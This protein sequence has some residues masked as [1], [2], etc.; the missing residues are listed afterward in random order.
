MFGGPP[1]LIQLWQLRGA[2]SWR[3]GSRRPGVRDDRVW[4]MRATRGRGVCGSDSRWRRGGRPTC[5]ALRRTLRAGRTGVDCGS[6]G[7]QPG[8]ATDSGLHSRNRIAYRNGG[9]RGGFFGRRIVYDLAI[10]GVI[11]I[12]GE[13]FNAGN[14]PRGRKFIGGGSIEVRGLERGIHLRRRPRPED[15]PQAGRLNFQGAE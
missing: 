9:V 12:T 1:P 11:K 6:G 10:S 8:L 3:L 13:I 7:D 2:T 5:R 14:G 15:V 4:K